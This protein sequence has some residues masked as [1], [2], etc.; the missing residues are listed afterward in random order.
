MS[1]KQAQEALSKGWHT[2]PR[3][4]YRQTKNN[5]LRRGE[6][7]LF[8]YESWW[9]LCEPR[10]EEYNARPMGELQ[11]WRK[12]AEGPWEPQNVLFILVERV[13]R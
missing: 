12:S 1:I 5:A 13:D 4:K 10:W 7:W 9:A 2:H 11:L 6:P 3:S 8:T